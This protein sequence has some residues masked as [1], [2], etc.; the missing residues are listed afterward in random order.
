[1]THFYSSL[2]R[3]F[4]FTNTFRSA[5]F[6]SVHYQNVNIIKFIV[7]TATHTVSSVAAVLLSL[8]HP[9]VICVAHLDIPEVTICFTST[10][11]RGNR[12]SKADTWS[13]DPYMR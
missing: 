6:D 11:L 2:G 9:V 8:R 7:C 4:S 3:S 13:L 1:M 12:S 10:L 5:I